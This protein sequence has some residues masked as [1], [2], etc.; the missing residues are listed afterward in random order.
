MSG[1]ETLDSAA[2]NKWKQLN[3]IQKVWISTLLLTVIVVAIVYLSPSKDPYLNVKAETEVLVYRVAR[4]DLA[5]IMLIGASITTQAVCQDPIAS[6]LSDFVGLLRPVVGTDVRYRWSAEMLS[7]DI[8]P[9]ANTNRLSSAPEIEKSRSVESIA[10]LENSDGAQCD[11]PEG[12]RVFVPRGEEPV[13]PLPIAGP[14]EIG[15]PF[16]VPLTPRR[17]ATRHTGIMY[18]A[19]VQVYGRAFL[20]DKLYPVSDT[21]IDIP[22]GSSLISPSFAFNGHNDDSENASHESGWYGIAIPGDR[23]FHVTAT[24]DTADLRFYRA[25]G[26]SETEEFDVSFLIELVRDPTLSKIILCLGVA[27]L[28]LQIALAYFSTPR[29]DL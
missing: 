25:G 5:G 8:T 15:V 18:G 3:Y 14:L 17:G 20:T 10:K 11:L 19:S 1:Q 16:G 13:V 4:Q 6:N 27:T 12:S 28:I 9:S 7:I 23:G 24:V 22:T 29:S 26:F 21:P 2:A